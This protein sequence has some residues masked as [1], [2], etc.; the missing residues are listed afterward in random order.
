MPCRIARLNYTIFHGLVPPPHNHTPRS[1]PRR[2][3][4]RVIEMVATRLSINGY[5]IIGLMLR[6]H[7]RRLYAMTASHFCEFGPATQEGQ[8][9][10]DG[11]ANAYQAYI[12]VCMCV[13]VSRTHVC[14]AG[15]FE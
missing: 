13:R 5:L 15:R 7:P 8:G 1:S 4:P 6:S 11:N 2:S 12:C 3:T 10:S 14:A 9:K